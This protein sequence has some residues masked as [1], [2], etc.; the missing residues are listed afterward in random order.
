MFVAD[1]LFG[2]ILTPP[3]FDQML[4]TP[5][6]Q[7][8][9]DVRLINTTTS[10]LAGL[11]DIRRFTHT[12]GVLH[13]AA[14]ASARLGTA[15]SSRQLD[16]LMAALILHDVGTPAYGH[17][18]EYLLNAE[19]GFTHEAMARQVITG[20]H[21][22]AGRFQQRGRTSLRLRDSLERL[23]LD[24]EEVAAFVLG[25]SALG[26]L[27]AGSLD[28]DNLDN[29]YR[30]AAGLGLPCHR[31]SL[32]ALAQVLDVDPDSG[33]LVLPVS[34]LPDVDQWLRLRRRCYEVIA[35]DEQALASQAMLTECLSL[36]LE[37]GLLTEADWFRTDEQ[38]LRR[39]LR[40]DIGMPLSIRDTML[41][42]TTGDYFDTIVIGWYQDSVPA[43]DLRRATHR[44]ALRASLEERLKMPVF[45]YVFYDSGTFEKRLDLLCPA[46]DGTAVAERMG[47]TSKST[48]VG[49]F[50]CERIGPPSQ[51]LVTRTEESLAEF[52]LVSATLATQPDRQLVYAPSGKEF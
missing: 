24:P 34:A 36:A 10:S 42:F 33:R 14:R 20:D 37:R 19:F 45:P 18:F 3:R 6:V 40:L 39:L 11:S 35:F 25:R 51:A 8:L 9:R 27:V 49:L 28:F 44:A 13:L 31:E 22:G 50:T 4:R 21:E 2:P 43:V 52:G 12:V 5:A 26:R 38:L 7:R 17:L 29:V 1:P 30:M 15:W 41:R 47:Q 16:T 23:D 32:D 48:I 46:A